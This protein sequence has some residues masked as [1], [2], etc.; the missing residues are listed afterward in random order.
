MYGWFLV[1]IGVFFVTNLSRKDIGFSLLR[2]TI[3]S[4]NFVAIFLTR[5]YDAPINSR[6]S[7]T[8]SSAEAK[9]VRKSLST[10]W[11]RGTVC[12]QLITS[13]C[14]LSDDVY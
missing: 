12:P 9:R 6:G 7:T 10:D 2:T 3:V 5:L 1:D 4:V 14:G 13:S 8:S 11:L